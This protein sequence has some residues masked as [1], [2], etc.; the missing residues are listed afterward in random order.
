MSIRSEYHLKIEQDGPSHA[1]V[2]AAIA[3]QSVHNNPARRNLQQETELWQDV[4]NGSCPFDWHESEHHMRHVSSQW[5]ET[6][7][8]LTRTGMEDNGNQKSYFKHGK[9]QVESQPAWSPSDF[10][11][12]KLR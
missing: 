11:P 10:D 5:P 7:F 1:D 4:I 2:A 3:R 12:A 9:A 8:T 6:L